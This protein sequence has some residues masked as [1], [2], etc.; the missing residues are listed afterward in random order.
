MQIAVR[1]Q[2]NTRMLAFSCTRSSNREEISG[3]YEGYPSYLDIV[4]LCSRGVTA[5][6]ESSAIL[7]NVRRI[8][9]NSRSTAN[10]KLTIFSYGDISGFWK[11]RVT[12]FG[13]FKITN[14]VW[15]RESAV[16]P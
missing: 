11:K 6:F 1:T 9:Q 2:C 5:V 14:P 13:S 12:N 10:E 15:E 3:M 7:I 4:M 8:D 16:V